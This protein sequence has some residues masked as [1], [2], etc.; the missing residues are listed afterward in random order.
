MRAGWKSA[1]DAFVRGGLSGELHYIKPR[2]I[3]TQT[4]FLPASGTRRFTT[5]IIRGAFFAGIA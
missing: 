4:G 5:L 1:W 2:K 3:R